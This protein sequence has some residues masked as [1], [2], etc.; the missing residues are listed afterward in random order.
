MKA[1]VLESPPMPP[2][3]FDLDPKEFGIRRQESALQARMRFRPELFPPDR[4]YE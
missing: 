1:P 2:L 3:S 4:P